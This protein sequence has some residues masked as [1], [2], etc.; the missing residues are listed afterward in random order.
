[1]AFLKQDYTISDE[2]GVSPLEGWCFP[3][4]GLV[5]PPESGMGGGAAPAHRQKKIKKEK[6][7]GGRERGGGGAALIRTSSL[8]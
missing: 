6:G 1:M 2:A 8:L 4:Q 5:Y 3:S 7:G